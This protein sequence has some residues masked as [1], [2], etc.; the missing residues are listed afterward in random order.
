MSLNFKFYII[1]INVTF[2]IGPDLWCQ[3]IILLVKHFIIILLFIA[4]PDLWCEY[5][6]T[7]SESIN[8]EEGIVMV[9][10]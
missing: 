2:I 8:T 6:M 9:C 7:A 3:Y 4:G 10:S 5:M 1:I